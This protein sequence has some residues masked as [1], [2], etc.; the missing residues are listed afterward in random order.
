MNRVLTAE[1][2][3]DK[4]TG[5]LYRYVLSETEFLSPH[6]HD[7]YEI[8]IV[9]DGRIKHVVNNKE[10]ILNPRDIVFIRPDD[11]HDHIALDG[12]SFSRL[13]I[14]FL[15]E[16]AKELFN[17]LGNGFPSDILIS[18]EFP[19]TVHL[20][21]EEANSIDLKMKNIVALPSENTELLKSQ[22]RILLFDIFTNYFSATKSSS[23]CPVW[24]QELCFNMQ[25]I[26]NFSEG[27]EKMYSLCT[28]SREHL[29]RSIK[30]YMNTTVSEYINNLRLNYISS[31]LKNSDHNI[32]EI[33]FDSGFNNISWA[34]E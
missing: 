1:R 19:P 7:Y 28:K 31:M 9:L 13:N 12:K 24:L 10:F 25:K 18:E 4:N 6:F 2:F 30:K 17:Y 16:T 21:A 34:N 27:T 29:S 5:F 32:I 22:L 15:A 3:V 26:E 8:F 20:T 33:V 23:N 14:T 11:I